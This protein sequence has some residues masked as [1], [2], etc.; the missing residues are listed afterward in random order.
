M[1]NDLLTYPET[2]S[3][4]AA[5]FTGGHELDVSSARRLKEKPIWA[6]LY[7]SIRD[8]F[9][10][11][12]LPP[13]E[14]TSTPIPVP[15]RMAVKAN[16]G[17]SASA[18]A[19]NVSILALL[20]FFG[21][22]EDHRHGA[23]SNSCTRPTSM[24]EHSRRPR[25]TRWLAAAAVAAT[26]ASSMP[27]K[28]KLPKIEKNPV[29]PPRCRR[30]NRAADATGDQRAEEHYLPDNPSAAEY[31]RD[32]LSQ[33]EAGFERTGL[34]GGMGTGQAAEWARETAMDMG[35]ALAAIPA[36]DSIRSAAEF[37][38]RCALNSVEAEFSDEARRAKYQGVCLVS[39]IV[40]AQAN[41]QN[42]RVVRALGMGLDE[43]ALEAVR[44][45]KFKPAMKDGKTPVPVM[46]TVEV[47]FRIL[48]IALDGS[49]QF[50]RL[51][52]FL[53]AFPF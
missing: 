49:E 14:L 25:P 39:L 45:Y 36:A 38:R 40:D 2:E 13:L 24:W 19:V 32:E 10:P 27:I 48:L 4:A 52:I 51:F 29:S 31:R 6:D 3:Q 7:E 47:N 53:S 21:V 23:S 26:T 8:V 5:A 17:P 22:Q 50:D 44:K 46:I 1:A 41:P 30:L 12:K 15:D 37:R 16:P 18:T 34:G 43:K 35:R 33:R 20:L 11:L 9:F 28:G 42:P